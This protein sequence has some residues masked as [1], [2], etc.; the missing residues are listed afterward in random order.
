MNMKK[1]HQKLEYT[2]KLGIFATTLLATAGAVYIYSPVIG[3]HATISLESD[4]NLTIDPSISVTLDKERLL[5]E[6]SPNEFVQGTIN[7]TVSTNSQYGYTLTFE[8]ADTDAR[9]VSS[10][11]AITDVFTSAFDGTKTSS[12]MDVNA[13]GYSLNATDF[14]KIPLKGN[15]VTLK[16]TNVPMTAES[17]TTAVDF[18]AKVG[19][20]TSG[21]YSDNVMFTAYTNGQDGRPESGP[22]VGAAKYIE[23]TLTSGTS[24]SL[25]AEDPEGNPRYVGYDPDNYVE[26]NGELWRIIGVFNGRVKIIRNE[27]IG[28]YSWDSSDDSLI[29]N[30][31]GAN[32]WNTSVLEEELNGDY[33]NS[34]L[35]ED[36][37]WVDGKF[38]QRNTV[39]DHTMVL[40][41]E[42]QNYID[43]ALWYLGSPNNDGGERAADDKLTGPFIYR[44][45]RGWGSGQTFFGNN[46]IDTKPR[47]LRWTGKVG[48]MYLS[49]Y[50]YATSGS[51]TISVKECLSS[52]VLDWGRGSDCTKNNWIGRLSQYPW[53]MS[54]MSMR[55]HN[56]RV[57]YLDIGWAHPL[58]DAT[59]TP[60]HV[61]PT[62][63]LKR[64]VKFASGTGAHDDPFILG[65]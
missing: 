56:Y 15:A 49:D 7:A 41:A 30:A 46:D 18:G 44:H 63:Y 26:Y 62:V 21:Y 58:G 16:Q 48:L 45:E 27:P 29:N 19:F 64:T 53:T 13:W 12:T 10:D 38:H 24:T 11:S 32:D 61:H 8:D 4:I 33:L 55:D 37:Y 14:R 31:S 47:H 20:I 9:L 60:C 51:E 17:E 65:F 36:T 35:S 22:S 39:F 52:S 5:L 34:E 59:D 57:F 2:S 3:S 23:D 40:T 6:A 42:S 25:A 1:N 50:A 54:P 28:Y 43:D